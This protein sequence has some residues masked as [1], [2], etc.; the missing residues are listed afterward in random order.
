LKYGSSLFNPYLCLLQICG[1]F[2]KRDEEGR[3]PYINSGTDLQ[4][5]LS[6]LSI[7][8]LTQFELED[9]IEE[10]HNCMEL[11]S[12][13]FSHGKFD[14]NNMMD[15]DENEPEAHVSIIA[16]LAGSHSFRQNL[17]KLQTD[18][19][20]CAMMQS[21]LVTF[22]SSSKIRHLAQEGKEIEISR[23]GTVVYVSRQSKTYTW[24]ILLSGK[25]KVTLDE[26]SQ[27]DDDSLQYELNPG[28][29]FGGYGFQQDSA[30]TTHI[31]IE[32]IQASKYIELSDE[33]LNE[34]VN[35]EPAAAAQLLSRMAGILK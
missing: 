31:K 12:N 2:Q 10:G 32:T 34:F 14:S 25:L 29:V 33:R 22:V 13:I 8:G 21:S 6:L 15:D 5:P 23:V 11:C 20:Y 35:Q 7:T 26:L 18:S 1:V 17:L 30:D 19:I 27:N 3:L 16:L 4:Y 24:C 28:E 9:I